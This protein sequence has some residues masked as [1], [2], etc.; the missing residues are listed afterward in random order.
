MA[1]FVVVAIF[2]NETTTL[3]E[4]LEHYKW[5]GSKHIYMG[6]NES[7]D[8]PLDILQPYIDEGFV[9]YIPF[10]GKVVQFDFYR[11]VTHKLQL[12]DSPPDWTFMVDLDEFWFGDQKPMDQ[13]L[14]EYP[15]SIDVVYR[16][17]REFGPSEDGFQPS[18]LRK[19]LTRRNP[20]ETSPKFGFRTLRIKPEQVWIHEIREHP[21]ERMVRETTKLHCH[22]YHCQ[23]LEHYMTV[24]IPRGY[25]L[26]DN[27]YAIDV[28]ESFYKRGALCTLVDTQ[29]ADQVRLYEK[30]ERR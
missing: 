28:N 9:T 6:D 7:T 26:G 15:D 27:I 2:K 10:P 11:L 16:S 21:D 29:L 30:N 23:S 1:N 22:H 13:V 19:E 24:R 12:L 8:N 20:A 25:A 3:K 17:W 5:Q 4:W 18:S 14:L